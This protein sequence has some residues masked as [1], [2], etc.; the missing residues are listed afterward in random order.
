MYAVPG[1]HFYDHN[2]IIIAKNIPPCN[3]DEIES[4]DVNKVYLSQGKLNVGILDRGTAW[5]ATGTFQ[6]FMQ[7]S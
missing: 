6:L 4:T 3:R 2:L 7:A 1:I 5:L